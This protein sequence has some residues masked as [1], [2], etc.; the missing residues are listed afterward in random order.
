MA[1]E[2]LLVLEGKRVIYSNHGL[3]DISPKSRDRILGRKL[4]DVLPGKD[5]IGL[6]DLLK[7]MRDTKG[8]AVSGVVECH[9]ELMGPTQLTVRGE[10]R[11]GFTY[12]SI[13]RPFEDGVEPDDRLMEVE[14]KLSALL[15][16]AAGAG[17]GVGVFEISPEGM[18]LPRSFNEHIISIFNRSQEEMVGKNPSE[19]MHPDDRPMMEEM[20]KELKETGANSAPLQMRAIDSTG[21]TIHIQVSNT[22][23]SPPN[24]HLGISFIQDLT[25]IREALDQQNRM[26]Q[27]IDRVEDSVVLADATGRVFYANSAALRSTGYTLEEVIGQPIFMLAAPEGIE[28][29]EKQGMGELLKRGYWRG[30]AMAFSKNGKRYPVEISGSVVR[31]D[32]GDLSMIVVISRKTLERQRFEGQLLMAKSNNERLS[33]H[34]EQQLL[35]GLMR[36]IEELDGTGNEDLA[37]V[38]DDLKAILRNGQE[39]L[40]EL[41]APE[42]AQTLRPMPL[43]ETLTSRIPDMISRHKV[44]GTSIEVTFRTPDEDVQVL[45]NDMLPDLIVKVLE[46]LMEMAEFG[47][48]KFTI[49]IGSRKVSGIKGTRPSGEGGDDEPNVATVSIACP[50]LALTDELKSILTRQELHTRGPLPPEQSLAVETSRLLLFIYEGRIIAERGQSTKDESLVIILRQP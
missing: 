16:L 44:G 15:G 41:P 2:W 10:T 22:M 48:P 42:E 33:E 13:G 31:D 3:V 29:F 28:D 34:V 35:P 25:P 24:D 39:V 4:T 26:V 11:N 21:E 27:A 47:H 14:D 43:A 45:A 49:T 36:T 7:R 50:G 8:E 37:S 40:A 46:V 38:M 23:L 12:L 20:V 9:D 32:Q 19:W 5:C 1:S 6:D 17:L 30:D 18:L